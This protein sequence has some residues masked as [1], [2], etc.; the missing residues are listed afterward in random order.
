LASVPAVV[1]IACSGSKGLWFCLGL[2]FLIVFLKSIFGKNGKIHKLTL[3]LILILA[4]LLPYGLYVSI[5]NLKTDIFHFT[6]FS[7]RLTTNLAGIKVFLLHPFGVGSA[8]LSYLPQEIEIVSRELQSF[9]NLNMQE[10]HTIVENQ[11]G[12]VAK[13]GIINIAMWGGLPVL[14]AFALI[15]ITLYKKV[16]SNALLTFGLVFIFFASLTYIDLSIKY[17]IWFFIVFLAHGYK[18]QNKSPSIG[19]DTKT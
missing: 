12:L 7:T 10:I 8:Y 2:T 3:I 6:S 1:F 19:N 15:W 17:E 13:S 9:G 16:K 18:E 14:L 5:G 11:Q 4:L